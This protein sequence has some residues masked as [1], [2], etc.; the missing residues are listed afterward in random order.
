MN[1]DPFNG[2][3]HFVKAEKWALMAEYAAGVNEVKYREYMATSLRVLA[4]A[5]GHIANAV[6]STYYLLDKVKKRLDAIERERRKF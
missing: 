4:E 5:S 3:N 2:Y 6:D 1:T